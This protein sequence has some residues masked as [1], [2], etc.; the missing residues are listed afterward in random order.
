[1]PSGLRPRLGWAT[2]LCVAATGCSNFLGLFGDPD[3]SI[4]LAV[5]GPPSRPLQMEIDVGGRAFRLDAP[6]SRDVDAPSTGELQVTV[7]LLSGSDTLAVDSFSQRFNDSDDHWIH[8]FVTDTR[9]LGFC[10]GLVRAHGLTAT[11]PDSL[12]VLH[13]SLPKNVIC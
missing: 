6:G 3:L 1:M 12:F 4:S 11:Q 13:G 2:L 7:R 10:L 5:Q 8:G 9:P